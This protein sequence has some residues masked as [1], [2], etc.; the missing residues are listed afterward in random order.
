MSVIDWEKYGNGIADNT[1]CAIHGEV[2]DIDAIL[3]ELKEIRDG[4][5]THAMSDHALLLKGKKEMLD[6]IITYLGRV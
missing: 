3:D 6:E 1:F 4:F 5:S 2:R